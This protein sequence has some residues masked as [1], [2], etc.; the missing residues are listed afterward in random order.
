MTRNVY[1]TFRLLLIL[2]VAIANRAAASDDSPLLEAAKAKNREAVIEFV[3]RG[4]DI[5]ARQADGATALHWASYWNDQEMAQVLISA[6]ANVN[7]ANDLGATPLWLAS[8]NRNPALLRLLLEAGANPNMA[9]ST[10]ETSLMQ[11]SL[12]GDAAAVGTLLRA[13]ANVNASE[14]SQGQ[15][16]L[17][18]AVSNGHTDIV[19][20]LLVFGADVHA[21]TR[22][23][24][25]PVSTS[26][27]VGVVG[28]TIYD[29]DGVMEVGAGGYTPLL[30]AARQGHLESAQLLIAAGADVDDTSG[31]GTSAL[32]VVAHSA[33]I[34]GRRHTAVG[35][36]LLE[37]GADP[38]A[39]AAGYT[40]IHA[41][42]LT[43]QSELVETLLAHGADP[44]LPLTKGTPV[45][46]FSTDFAFSK[47]LIG[48]TPLWLAAK[49]GEGHMVHALVNRGA[50]PQFAM[51]DGTTPLMIAI[52]AGT[53]E[54]R[55]D[56]MFMQ[57]DVMARSKAREPTVTFETATALLETG[58]DANASNEAGDTALHM[59]ARRRLDAVVQLLGD[60][61][62]RLD[63]KNKSGQTPLS[64]AS[65]PS[66]T[67]GDTSTADLLRRLGASEE[68]P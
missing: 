46:R 51:S 26:A 45:R 1:G 14:R 56:R 3:N 4:A 37:H 52:S 7:V 63:M 15:T 25:R 33:H 59:A 23:S 43:G 62:A 24:R 40:A 30:L 67:G 60:H 9:L 44:N 66:R 10:G 29:L 20:A 39:A 5:N 11:A 22:V 49:F 16:A 18:W 61:G 64:M 58:A 27:R 54:D 53:G 47:K 41:A 21:R 38:N 34:P 50:E 2:L 13:G 19:R 57:P 6:Q 31:Y 12:T 55:R 32:V 36:L 17:M 35:K 42:L 68:H 48:A 8:Q 65:S 28:G